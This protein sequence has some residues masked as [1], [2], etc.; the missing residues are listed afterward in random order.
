MERYRYS[1]ANLVIGMVLAT[2]IERSLHVS[3]TLYGNDFL[4]ERPVAL[5][6]FLL[7]LFTAVWPM[8]R[9]SRNAAARA[10]LEKGSA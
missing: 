6:M 3:L 4:L 5:A 1:R 10:A 2:M 8:V 7:V 9:G